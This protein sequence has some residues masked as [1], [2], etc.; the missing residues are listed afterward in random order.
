MDLF[1][2]LAI[3]LAI[4][5]AV[6]VERG[7]QERDEVAGG[8]TAGLRTFSLTG[9][10]GGI[11]GLLVLK[12]GAW[13]LA[14]VSLPL[15]AA[16]VVFAVQE[17]R[18]EKNWSVTAVVA[19]FVVYALG[20]YAMVGD[21]RLAS[22]AAVATIGLL[23]FRGFLHSWLRALTWAELRSA[24]ILLAMTFV[25]LPLLP[26][27]DMGPYGVFN[28]YQ[29]WMLTILIG[30]VSYLGYIA[31]RVFG[32][33]RGM[34]LAAAI[35]ALVSSTAVVVDLARRVK[36]SP[37]LAR[38]AVGAAMIAGAVMAARI[39]AVAIA[40]SRPLGLRLAPAMA[41]FA[42][43]SL[44]IAGLLAFRSERASGAETQVK[45]PLDFVEVLKFAGLLAGVSAVAHIVSSLFGSAGVLAVGAIAGLADVDA[46]TLTVGRMVGTSLSASFAAGAVLLAAASNSVAKTGIAFTAGGRRFGLGYGAAVATA[47][48]LA[49]VTFFLAPPLALPSP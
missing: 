13:A 2:R 12:V 37:D 33:G 11:T 4:G 45:S 24:L 40:L 25:V 9:L 48:V 20:V 42:L 19:A 3:A 46:V 16:Y 34:P 23:A 29:L 47:A 18:A 31:I 7:W 1:Q 6:G 30:G 32:A 28:P 15:G 39:F 44:G 36:E 49:A 43:A 14:A 22:A 21:W 38:P 5:F 8:R 10:L 35:G 27:E 26:D 41:V 17:A